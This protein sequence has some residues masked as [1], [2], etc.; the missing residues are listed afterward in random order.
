MNNT[1]TV[2]N[3]PALQSTQ[4]AIPASVKTPAMRANELKSLIASIKDTPLVAMT[5]EV[6]AIAESLEGAEIALAGSAVRQVGTVGTWRQ[7]T[8]KQGGVNWTCLDGFSGSSL[9]SKDGYT[10]SMKVSLTI[11]KNK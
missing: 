11:F 2:V 7:Y 5:P 9:F 6:K 8:T 1:S 4:D 3:K 10:V